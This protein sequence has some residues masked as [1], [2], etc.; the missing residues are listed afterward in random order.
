MNPEIKQITIT[1]VK[2]NAGH[3]KFIHL[4]KLHI[5]FNFNTDYSRALQKGIFFVFV[6][7]RQQI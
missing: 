5:Y 3:I 7:F 4:G 2:F 1:H 6:S